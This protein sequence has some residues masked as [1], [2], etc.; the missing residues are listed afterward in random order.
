M[1][2]KSEAPL[3]GSLRRG[4]LSRFGAGAAAIAGLAAA[5]TARA[6]TDKFQPVLHDQESWMA[7]P[8]K[9]RLVL[10]THAQDGVNNALLWGGNYIRTSQ[11]DFGLA[12]SDLAVII[13]VRHRSV[14]FGFND[15]MW[16]K[17]GTLF[18]KQLNFVDP[19]TKEA[20]KVNIYNYTEDG[21]PRSSW[22]T[23][24]KAGAQVAVCNSATRSTATMLAKATNQD[25]DAVVKELSANLVKNGRIVPA[26]I[27][28]VA[29][30]IERGY[31]CVATA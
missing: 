31:A 21:S 16:A 19:K 3:P 28:A 6:E 15:A 23:M 18:S 4:F 13:V 7:I 2:K 8:A 12:P 27:I 5:R 9:H 11:S 17:Y 10:D 30:A 1:S 24:A 14:S 29:H 26:G 20:P 25:V 22:E